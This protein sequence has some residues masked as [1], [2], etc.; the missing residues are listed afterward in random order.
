MHQT[1]TFQ[2]S[3]SLNAPHAILTLPWL[4]KAMS[5]DKTDF[6]SE[7]KKS[8]AHDAVPE[9]VPEKTKSQACTRGCQGHTPPKHCVNIPRLVFGFI[10]YLARRL[11]LCWLCI[12][13]QDQNK[14]L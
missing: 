14:V 12:Q 5:R 13:K 10:R 7:K 2:S 9:S 8:D 6:A 11:V 3:L 1:V 4:S